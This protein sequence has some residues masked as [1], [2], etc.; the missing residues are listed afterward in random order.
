MIFNA[1]GTPVSLFQLTNVND[2]PRTQAAP[3]QNFINMMGINSHIDQN[4]ISA[5]DMLSML[6]YLGVYNIRDGLNLGLLP[7]YQTLAQAGIHLET[8][9]GDVAAPSFPSLFEQAAALGPNF[10]TAVEGPNEINNFAFTLNGVQSS[11]GWPNDNGPMVVTY[12]NKLMG[13]VKNDTKLSGVS[14][15]DF[16]WGGTVGAESYG[17]YDLSN[18]ANYGNFHTYP[19]GQPHYAFL[20][21]LAGSYHNLT[22]PQTAITETGYTTKYNGTGWVSDNAQAI[23]DLNIYLD[24]FLEG[25]YKVYIYELYDEWQTY[26]VFKSVNNPKP[27]ATAIHN[28]TTILKDNGAP[29][30]NPGSL[31]Y[32][33]TGLPSQS[34]AML[35]QKSTGV[36]DLIIWYEPQVDNGG[37][38]VVVSPVNIN[39]ALGQTVSK[40]SV[41]DP[42]TS[43]SASSTKNS[44]S[45]LSVPLGSHPVILEITP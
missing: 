26:G 3:V 8:G 43:E 29:I 7:E 25:F 27:A 37:T 4:G 14:V 30:A 42:V 23:M 41:F 20:T 12:M 15:F 31:K 13:L 39:V 44:I 34:F 38:E 10:L 22:P 17:F 40:V 28:L 45:S 18:W 24:A 11:T 6:N 19:G 21:G 33:I 32:T 36:F 2:Q 1:T 5:P 16:T 35:L 9:A